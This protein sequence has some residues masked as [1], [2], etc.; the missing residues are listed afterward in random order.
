MMSVIFC[1]GTGE[2]FVLVIALAS[3]LSLPHDW[4]SL[5]LYGLVSAFLTCVAQIPLS[6]SIYIAVSSFAQ[7]RICL[8]LLPV[9][10]VSCLWLCLPQ[11]AVSKRAGLA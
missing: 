4:L 8:Y 7:V 5:Y 9:L 2:V 10:S 11:V 1:E 3:V 6:I